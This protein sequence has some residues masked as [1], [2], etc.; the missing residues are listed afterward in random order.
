MK[1]EMLQYI[2]LILSGILFPLLINYT[3][4]LSKALVDN[5]EAKI[6][7][8]NSAALLEEVRIKIETLLTSTV[9]HH[10]HCQGVIIIIV[11]LVPQDI[12]VYAITLKAPIHHLIKAIVCLF[13]IHMLPLALGTRCI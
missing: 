1:T 2:S 5:G 4:K 3:N 6:I 8:A 13:G 11:T 9:I 7:M 12:M 10:P